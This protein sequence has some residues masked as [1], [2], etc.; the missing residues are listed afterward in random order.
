MNSM[1]GNGVGQVCP[2]LYY[3]IQPSY[4]I[5]F[6][7]SPM[8]KSKEKDAQVYTYV[9][10]GVVL[11]TPKRIVARLRDDFALPTIVGETFILDGRINVIWY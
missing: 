1:V 10:K 5:N 3:K 6:N 11:S 2:S 7:P 8:T 4:N 9:R